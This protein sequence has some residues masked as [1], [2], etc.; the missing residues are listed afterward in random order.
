MFDK[1]FEA[2][3]Q[4]EEIKSRLDTITVSGEME[5]GKIRVTASANK[6]VKEISVE[7]EFFKNCD[8]E[9][10]EELLVVAIN[11]ALTQAES[12]SQAE[13]KAATQNM[14]GGL[15]GLGNMFK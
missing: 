8:R 9:E 6:E 7:E 11:K 3:K 10:L 13:M 2:Q 12:I 4:A 1:L 14:L 5:G 15:G